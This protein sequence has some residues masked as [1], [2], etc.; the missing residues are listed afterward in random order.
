MST[1]FELEKVSDPVGQINMEDLYEKKQKVD[2]E[3]LDL[4]NKIL[5]KIHMRIKHVSNQRNQP[6]ILWYIVPETIIGVP[7]Y[8]QPA[9]VVYLLSQL[10]KNGFMVKYIFP[11]LLCICWNHYIPKYVRNKIYQNTGVNINEHGD[12]VEE[13][14]HSNLLS[15]TS[16][17]I[18][19][20]SK[21]PKSDKTYTPLDRYKPT[22]NLIYEDKYLN[23]DK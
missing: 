16:N 15:D 8:D 7:R 22:G 10:E 2:K 13:E 18:P 17:D 21:K 19:Q 6:L 5:G 3:Q 11:N 12:T 1:V 14:D 20:Y 4:F 9:C 23:I